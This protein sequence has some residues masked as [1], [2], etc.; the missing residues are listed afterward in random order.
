MG[1]MVVY[2]ITIDIVAYPP[3][4]TTNYRVED[5]VLG[6]SITYPLVGRIWSVRPMKKM[7]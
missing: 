1:P 5:P 6:T 4:E 2:I 3:K 7:V